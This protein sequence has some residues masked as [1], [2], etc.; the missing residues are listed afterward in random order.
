MAIL[1]ISN[2]FKSGASEIG[3]AIE[4]QL[5]YAFLSQSQIMHEASQ[6]GKEW[7]RFTKEYGSAAPT[8]WERYDWSFMGFMA[9]V[10]SITLDHAL[11]D[12]TVIM[13]R[14]A[15]YLLKDI[16]HIL[17]IRVAAP[18][19]RRIERIMA[20]EG[21]S[22][23]TARLLVK[24]ADHEVIS[25]IQQLYGK[26]WSDPI[27]YEIRFDTSMNETG[28]IAESIKSLLVAKDHLKT[29]KGQRLLEMRALA[30]KIKA[31]IF[32]NPKFFIPTLEVKST[33]E[34]ISLH[35]VAR[36]IKEHQAIHEEVKGIAQGTPVKCTILYRGMMSAKSH[37][38]D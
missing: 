1:S 2:E 17:R 3:H 35:G 5:G 6:A 23:K 34:G 31:R 8:I 19:E 21:L 29:P 9:L 10:Q 13:S 27:A 37:P 36:S 33:P 25:A 7:A 26:K 32:I 22:W 18:Q 24:K 12:N 30:A 15:N 16:P 28:Q 14:G 38:L 4:K 11:Q 20:Q